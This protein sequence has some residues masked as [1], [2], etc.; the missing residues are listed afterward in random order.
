MADQDEK[1]QGM[2]G[3]DSGT[4][5]AVSAGDLLAQVGRRGRGILDHLVLA[6]TDCVIVLRPDATVGSVNQAACQ[7]LGYEEA[8]LVG[9]RFDALLH[10][11]SD[12]GT[13]DVLAEVFASDGRLKF[14]ETEL[15]RA[16]GHRVPAR[17][18][19]S[20]AWGADGAL[21]GF[22]CVAY[23]LSPGRALQEAMKTASRYN[24]Y[25]AL[26]QRVAMAANAARTPEEALHTAVVEVCRHAGWALGHVYLKDADGLLKP[27]SIWHS[28][29]DR[30]APFI[31]QTR[32]NMEGAS[33]GLPGRVLREQRAV[34][35]SRDESGPRAEIAR[36][37]GIEWGAGF[38][39][40]VG[41][42]VAAILEFFSEDRITADPKLLEVMEH[43]GAQLG[44]LLQRHRADEALLQTTRDYRGLFENAYDA[45]LILDARTEAVLDANPSACALY[46]LPHEQMLGR[47]M[48]SFA[49]D[50]T[51]T[52]A[53]LSE[54]LAYGASLRFADVHLRTDGTG[55]DLEV[56]TSLIEYRSRP[57]VL[58]INRDMTQ[59]KAA[60]EAL[61][62]SEERY[63]LAAQAAN[64]GLWDWDLVTGKVYYSPRWYAMLGLDPG[65]AK[66][67]TRA[68]FDLVHPEDA[69]RLQYELIHHI[70][71]ATEFFE[72]EHRLLHSDG[73][74]RW[75]LS[76]GLAVRGTDGRAYRIAGSLSDIT[77]R[78]R[79]EGQLVHDAL[80][81]HLTGLPSRVLFMDRLTR[82]I[83]RCKRNA[84]STF[85]VL[86]LDLDAFK[87][88]NESLGHH[89][90]DQLLIEIGR[91]IQKSLR[92]TD[93][94]ARLGGDEFAILIEDIHN[95]ADC[96]RVAEHI[97]MQMQQ[98][99]EVGSRDVFASG[100]IGIALST[101]GYERA[102]DLLRDADTAMYRAKAMGRSRHVVFDKHMHA[103]ALALLDLETA[104]RKAV[105]HKELA[106]H[107][108][109]IIA[110]KSGRLAGFE[111]L[112]RW[113]RADG[114][115]VSPLEFIPLAEAT[116]LIVPLGRWVLEESC[117]LASRWARERPEPAITIAVNISAKQLW[118]AGFIEDLKAILDTTG[119]PAHL[120]KLELTESL[121]MENA[122]ASAAVLESLRSAGVAL[123]IDDFGTGYSSLSYLQR[124]PIHTIK[125]DRSFVSGMAQVDSDMMIV[126]T[127]VSLAHS[128]GLDLVAEG[129]ETPDQMARLRAL[130]CE[131]GQGYLFSKPVT[132]G[133]AEALIHSNP[134]W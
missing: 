67:A 111:A 116:G 1:A 36:Q 69:V 57:A 17:L 71:G 132:V 32:A 44:H 72:S 123:S 49:M 75:I 104:L 134:K 97:H 105:E 102:E 22:V 51:H 81:D 62:K 40:M 11:G 78:K 48:S 61:R 9:K 27:T 92:S 63:A 115:I 88:I 37:V 24:V 79:V 108:Q 59:H 87:L 68:W 112:V 16:D 3:A 85:A 4:V 52:R 95:L 110:L 119:L 80:H 106:L 114:Q 74:Y 33:R 45:I 117:R 98:P 70:E 93:T 109:P 100:S 23:D 53:K 15:V 126:R 21:A 76:R 6:V 50:P 103:S 12:A 86:F 29:D 113:P 55:M 38:P 120:L 129:V 26:L 91:R 30:F 35:K 31:E 101:T 90:G 8:E 82:A 13:T 99:F 42:E 54:T 84:Q 7:M 121:L 25:V 64:D 34:W 10:A 19:G 47:P 66:H 122:E 46:G 83:K 89:A 56:N 107:L 133:E 77:E 41:G 58:S 124:F 20:V 60:E 125:I 73:E 96:T 118:H 128:L 14:F 2:P 5:S 39:V 65:A 43:V 130:G 131:F 28:A 127:I 94:V 18:S